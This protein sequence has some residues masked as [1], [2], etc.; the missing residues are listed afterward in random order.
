MYDGDDADD[1][2]KTP[3]DNEPVLLMDVQFIV[4]ND[5]VPDTLS[6]PLVVTP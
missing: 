5:D 3:V 1:I 2:S 6:A 4:A